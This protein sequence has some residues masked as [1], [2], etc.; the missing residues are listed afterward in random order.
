[1]KKALTMLYTHQK[2]INRGLIGYTN[3]RIETQTDRQIEMYKF[4]YLDIF[5]EQILSNII[6]LQGLNI[7][8]KSFKTLSCAIVYNISIFSYSQLVSRIKFTLEKI[9]DNCFFCL[10]F[11]NQGIDMTRA[12][13]LKLN[14]LNKY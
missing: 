2:A 3:R 12:Q 5:L 7:S 10:T 11:W 14:L 9:Y 8:S 1:M 13:K 6:F 4:I